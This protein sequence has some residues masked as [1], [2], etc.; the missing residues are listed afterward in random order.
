MADEK[1]NTGPAENISPEAAEPIATP[2]QAAASEPQQE[3]T[4]PAIPEPGDVVVSFDKIN[5]LMAEKR[6]NARA[7]VE[8]AETPEAQEAAAPGE[9][10]QPAN[11]EEPKKPRRGRPPKAEKAA[12]E[13]Q[14]S[15][16]SAGARKGRPPK[17][18]KT[19]PDKPKPSKR[20]KVSRSDGKAPDAKEPIKP[21][22]DTAPKETAT[23]EQTAPEP[24]TPPRPVEEG[25]LVYLK[26]SE[27]H[28][29]HTFR[30][31]PF[32]V[33]DD[34]KMQEIVASIRVNGVMVPGLAR[35]EKDGN[36]YEI[37]A[38]H[39]RT[40]G[41][42][43][44]GLAEMPFIVREMTDH[45]AVQAMKDSNKQRDGMLP[46]ELAALLEL[47]VE[48]IKHQGGRLKGVA[49]G[50][51]GKRSVEIVGEA[52]E[53]NYKK[54][55]RYLRL[56]SLVP[57][58]LDKV[59]DK[60]MGFMPAVELSYIKPKNQ[61]LIA[62][63][64]DGEQASPSLAQAKRLRE[65][66]KE[67]KLNGDVIDGILSEQKKEDRGVIISTAELEKYFGKEVT[68]AKMKEQ[69][70][71][72][73]DDWKRKPDCFA[74][75]QY[76]KYKLASGKTAKSILI[77]CGA[78]LAPFD[79]AELREIMSYDELELDK[80]GDEKTA[81]FF[82]I[83]DTDST[84]NFIVAL[85]FSQMFNLLCERADNKYGGRLPH[86]VRV[87][88]DEAANT[89][90]VPGLEKI[91][92]V[93]RSREISLTLFY[94][95]MSQCKA[96][97]KD[98]AE[99]IMGNMDSIVFLG[100]RE[101]S[102]LKD[103]SENWLGKATISMQTDSRTRGQSESYGLNTQRLGRE[104]LTTSEIT[105]MPGN[106]CLLQ[107][108]GLPPFFSPKYDLKQ[109]PNYRY[110]AEHD[111]KRN[112]FHLERLTS[113]RL[114]LKPEEEYTVYEVDASDEDADIL[115]YDDLDSADDFV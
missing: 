83:S 17:A 30:P 101:A 67:G 1:L 57:E 98:H 87:L 114:R 63:S 95:A 39:R 49:E 81:L 110:T 41:S 19:A 75:K 104:L 53:M 42:E 82:L 65:L 11:T 51:V 77:S 32:K 15:E 99:T 35:P 74:V 34:A 93:I 13:N 58:L 46:S 52:H 105:T 90:Q 23:A 21:A 28:P 71:S 72:L 55:M 92:A 3:Q 29:F 12:T 68:P 88:W 25:K 26:L 48:D 76:K 7:E 108:R 43:L 59:D 27:V 56:N 111:S 100:G 50:D 45:E 103:I 66:D 80:L 79:I 14:K 20:D 33:R 16:K 69:I 94:Q 84:Y 18:D 86:H 102:T 9:T 22:Q 106:K 107:L 89:G 31:H 70:M 112:A 97:Y 85:A 62:V 109:H 64:I 60:K 78:R 24:T 91:V 36:G 54:V 44:A 115:N 37:V 38:G 40:H 6:Q 4:G 10:P 47:E 2:E 8:K 5:E 113:R 96:L 61:R 73:L